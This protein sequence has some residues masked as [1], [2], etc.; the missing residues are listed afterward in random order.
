VL[1]A[2]VTF[3]G[4]GAFLYLAGTIW[5][6]HAATVA[7][8]A[9]IGVPMLLVSAAVSSTSF[10][11]RFGRWA[12][13]L[14]SLSYRLPVGFNLLVYLSGLALTATPGKL[15]ETFRSLLL[16]GRGV[17]VPHSLGAFVTDRL[18]DLLGVCL[19]GVAAGA[20]A[21]GPWPWLLTGAFLVLFA[22]S[23]LAA[24]AVR[25]PI[26]GA[27]W[28]WLSDRVRWL[29]VSGGQAALDAWATL[30]APGRSLLFATLAILA[31]GTQA[32]VFVEICRRA[33]V[34]ILAPD[35]VMIFVNAT[36]FGA[37]SMVPGGLGTMEAAL[38]YQL[39]ERGAAEHDAVSIAV[40][41]RLVTLWM[42]I[43]VG[44]AS[45][46]AI[47]RTSGLPVDVQGNIDRDRGASV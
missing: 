44:V 38:V 2:I 14:R 40:A 28:H 23:V 46:F 21:A 1:R 5:A 43:G 25:H 4:I 31:Y 36:L 15:G 26:S 42:G 9:K 10:L 33:G 47:A 29:P 3:V 45:L 39:M 37:A 22:T 20:M 32:L 19:L 11:W 8:L 12:M 17:R 41:I 34:P 7:S 35:G 16:A 27:M 30:W 6:G 24:A 13:C 18:S